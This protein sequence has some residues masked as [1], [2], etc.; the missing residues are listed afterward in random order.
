M[1]VRERREKEREQ[2]RTAIIEAAKTL[3]SNHGLDGVSMDRIAHEAELAKGT[4]YL[5]FKSRE[6]LMMAIISNE[7]EH[8]VTA[9]EKVASTRKAP[10][11]QLLDAVHTFYA[12]S[13]ESQFFY[14]LMMQVNIAHVVGNPAHPSDVA[15]QFARQNQR[16]FNVLLGIVQRG[17][18]RGDFFLQ[19]PAPYVVAQMIIS[20]KGAMVILTNDMMPPFPTAVPPLKQLLSDI[21]NLLI[22]GLEHRPSSTN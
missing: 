5:Y 7:L 18:D 8:L 19:H 3:Y 16:M 17:V 2:R 13:R 22:R 11:Q 20:L 21:A 6:E 12:L 9:L 14:R 15:E 10:R 1:G 4:I